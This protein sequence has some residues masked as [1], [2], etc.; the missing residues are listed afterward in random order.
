MILFHTL[1]QIFIMIGTLFFGKR[2][3]PYFTL[4][5]I[6]SIALIVYLEVGNNIHPRIGRAAL[7]PTTAWPF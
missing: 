5:A 6:A 2:A 4:A 3:A 7:L 1:V